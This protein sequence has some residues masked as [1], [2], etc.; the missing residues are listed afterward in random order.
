MK[1]HRRLGWFAAVLA[2][3][4]VA[5]AALGAGELAGGE[6]CTP[7]GALPPE[8]L[9]I[10]FSGVLCFAILF[11]WGVLLR[12][13]TAAHR[14]VMILSTIAMADAGFARM[15]GLFVPAQTTWIGQYFFYFGGAWFIMLSMFL[16]DWYKGRVMRQFLVGVGLIVAVEVVANTLYFNAGWQAFA[17]H[18][19][20]SL[21]R[22]S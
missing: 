20:G 17:R 12:G 10:A 8:F 19:V 22:H 3:P 18:W 21:A 5:A 2:A 15:L 1:L 7:R 13:N 16:W 6:S 11:P 9:S 14:R 4:T